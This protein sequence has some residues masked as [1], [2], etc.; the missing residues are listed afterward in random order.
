MKLTVLLPLYNEFN[1]IKD[2]LKSLQ[3][4][5]YDFQVLISDNAS[6]DGTT[7]LVRSVIQ[8]D[9]RFH[10][11]LQEKNLGAYSNFLGLIKNVKTPFFM[12]LGGHDFISPGYFERVLPHLE[13]DDNISMAFGEPHAVNEDGKHL[14][15]LS[16]ALYDF[17][18]QCRLT[19]YLQSVKRLANCTCFHSIYRSRDANGLKLRKTISADHVFISHFLWKGNIKYVREAKYFRRHFERGRNSTQSERIAGTSEY[20]SRHD[21][22]A[23]YI[24]SFRDLYGENDNIRS[25]I[26][27][28]MLDILEARWGVQALL[29]NDGLKIR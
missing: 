24:E 25:Y 26:E 20:L 10:L 11:F 12:V 15:V 7:D 23:Y 4:Q 27:H 5:N 18:N 29:P 14:G 6:I 22:L 9:D 1:Y 2:T 19:R 17:N 13:S 16:G 3:I 21:F 8:G 28:K